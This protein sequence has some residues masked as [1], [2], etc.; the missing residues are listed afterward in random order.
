MSK[1]VANHLTKQTG[2]LA[3]AQNSFVFYLHTTTLS[4][5]LF[6]SRLTY[7]QFFR[8]H[9]LLSNTA[10]YTHSLSLSHPSD[11]IL[12]SNGTRI[13]I[14]CMS[15]HQCVNLHQHIIDKIWCVNMEKKILSWKKCRRIYY[16]LNNNF[17][18]FQHQNQNQ[19][20]FCAYIYCA[21]F[22]IWT[23]S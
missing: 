23:Q 18:Q 17:R 3:S 15:R 6:H 2:G 7:T 11:F 5:T 14:Y 12:H 1:T 21:K 16:V 22:N 20:E 10:L 9:C 8:S 19:H 4:Y 13:E